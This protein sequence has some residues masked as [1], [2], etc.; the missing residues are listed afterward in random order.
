MQTIKHI[1]VFLCFLFGP[2]VLLWAGYWICVLVYYM[3]ESTELT[4]FTAFGLFSGLMLAVALLPVYLYERR[5][6]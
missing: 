3:T 2:V 4:F 5:I 6:W 1:L